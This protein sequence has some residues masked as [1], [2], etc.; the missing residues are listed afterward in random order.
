MSQVNTMTIYT[1]R[2]WDRELVRVHLRVTCVTVCYVIK[3]TPR[4]SIILT[5]SSLLTSFKQ[6]VTNV[7]HVMGIFCWRNLWHGNTS[8]THMYTYKFTISSSLRSWACTCASTCYLCYCVLRHQKY[9]SR[10][11]RSRYTLLEIC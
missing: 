11:L 9:P 8:N 5:C 4:R 6:R 1:K 2:V 7:N 3:N 10:D